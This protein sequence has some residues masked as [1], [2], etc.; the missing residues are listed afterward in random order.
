VPPKKRVEKTSDLKTN[1]HIEGC[2][3]NSACLGLPGAANVPAADRILQVD[4]NF[5]ASADGV[6]A[7]PKEKADSSPAFAGSE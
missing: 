3:W 7:N 6:R 2:Q 4:E 1:K 5:G